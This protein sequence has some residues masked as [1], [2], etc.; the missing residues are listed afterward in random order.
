MQSGGLGWQK[1]VMAIPCEIAGKSAAAVPLNVFERYLTLWVAVCIVIGVAVGQVFPVSVQRVGSMEF[2]NVNLPVG[3]LIWIMIIPMLLKIDFAAWNQIRGHV[4]GIGVT[5]FINWAVKPFSMAFLGWLFIR[6]WFA[7]YLPAEQLDSYVAGLILLAAAPCTAMV[8]VWSRLTGGDPYFTLS[9]VALNDLIMV[10]AFAPLVALLLGVSSIT[11]PWATLLTS[12]GLYIVVPVI[13]AQLWRRLLLRRGQSVFDR[14]MSRIQ[15][16][17]MAALLL[18]LILLFAFQGNAIIKQP[19]VIVLLA[20]PILI[21]VFFNSALAYWLNRVVGEKHSVACPSALIGASNFF[22][23][24]VA[25]AISLFGF[26]SGAA[27]ATVVGVLIEVPV[28]L[29][30]VSVVNRTRGWYERTS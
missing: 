3:L 13:I 1:I 11:V 30:V 26:D 16:W 21:Q 18:T 14:V 9:Q 4:R 25:A 19:V 20:V 24:A 7:P 28:M 22:E 5:L 6:H 27:L 15:P 10:F 12:V 29:L 8:F 23:L 17:S 2:A